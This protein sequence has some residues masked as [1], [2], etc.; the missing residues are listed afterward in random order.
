MLRTSIVVIS[1]AE[2]SHGFLRSSLSVCKSRVEGRAQCVTNGAENPTST[3][4]TSFPGPLPLL[5]GKGPGNE[6]VTLA[7]N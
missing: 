1:I 4:A 3:L 6:V 2:L 5:G 7:K